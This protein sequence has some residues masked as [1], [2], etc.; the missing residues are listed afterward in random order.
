MA[1]FAVYIDEADPAVVIDRLTEHYPDSLQID[2]NLYLIR[3]DTI[4]RNI[5]TTLGIKGEG[6]DLSGV[7]FKLNSSYS[8]FASRAIWDWL[9]LKEQ[10]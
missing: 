6:R 2:D 10:A 7:V 1:V 4:A 8:G 9:T 5:A 3:D